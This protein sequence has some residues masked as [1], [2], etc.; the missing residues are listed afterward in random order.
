[1][2]FQVRRHERAGHA[3]AAR[4]LAGECS[5][6]RVYANLSLEH[7]LVKEVPK[8]RG[9]ASTTP[10]SG[11]LVE[12]DESGERAS[13][14][15]RAPP[16]PCDAATAPS[17]SCRHGAGSRIAPYPI[18]RTLIRRGAARS[19]TSTCVA[20]AI[21]STTSKRSACTAGTAWLCVGGADAGG[22]RCPGGAPF[23]VSKSAGGLSAVG[24]ARCLVACSGT[25]FEIDFDPFGSSP[26][27]M[28]FG[29]GDSS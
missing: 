5:V 1:M 3:A 26:R 25:V 18:W 23:F 13:C 14:V 24:E 10:R 21:G 22:A 19:C 12:G 20:K 8:K 9:D 4:V 15:S 11:E 29:R 17:R 27:R 2:A 16:I 6:E 7:E 28:N